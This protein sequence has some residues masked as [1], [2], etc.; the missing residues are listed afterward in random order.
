MG[1]FFAS[2]F[3]VAMCIKIGVLHGIMFGILI[4]IVWTILMALILVP[5]DYWLTRKLPVEALN[6]RQ[7]RSINLK[8]EF[9]SIY[10][11][12]VEVIRNIKGVRRIEKDNNPNIIAFTR[13]SMSSVGERISLELSQLD[14]ETINIH[15]MSQP[16]IKF[17]MLDYGKN[18][19]NVE[20]VANQLVKYNA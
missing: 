16:I 8:G 7:E 14:Q 2:L 19:K 5:I 20:S 17:T 11:Y 4:S 10:V 18:Y 1:V 3:V 15:I 12:C 6:V 9:N 13:I